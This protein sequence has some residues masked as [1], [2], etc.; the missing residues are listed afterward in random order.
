MPRQRAYVAKGNKTSEFYVYDWLADTSWQSLSPIPPGPSGKPPSRGCRGTGDGL[1]YIYMVKG[2]NT[3]EFWR[4][5]AA[6]DSWVQM[7]DVPESPSGKRVKSGVD[8]VHTTVRDTGCIFLLKG[9]TDEFL[10]YNT[11]SRDWRFLPGAPVTAKTGYPEGSWLAPDDSL[12]IYAHRARYHE[13]RRFNIQTGT[14]DTVRLR[15]MPFL[16]CMGRNKKSKDGGAADRFRG[17]ILAIKGGNTNEFWC[18]NTATDSWVERETIPSIGVTFKKLKVKAGGDIV[19]VD[20]GG[21]LYAL[22]GK[23]LELWVYLESDDDR[24]HG[25]CPDST[26]TALLS[27]AEMGKPCAAAIVSGSAAWFPSWCSSQRVTVL[28]ASGRAVRR[29]QRLSGCFD[30]A[31]LRSG[32]YFIRAEN[33]GRASIRRMQIIR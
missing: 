12:H 3:N 5:D 7:P 19:A 30:L 32:V 13:L 14:W 21:R 2:N 18:Y 29:V 10:S 31:D 4:Y 11:A 20:P 33:N 28:D 26:S 9:N 8:L 22:K 17:R 1:R 25:P 15:G 16:G 6:V 24:R 27:R 23:S